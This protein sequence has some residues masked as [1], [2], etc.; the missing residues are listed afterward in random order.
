MEMSYYDEDTRT[1]STSF[2]SSGVRSLANGGFIEEII[3][4]V[5]EIQPLQTFTYK[6]GSKKGEEGS[7]KI[8]VIENTEQKASGAP[9]F[10][11]RV[12]IWADV[13]EK[14]SS[15]TSGTIYKLSHFKQVLPDNKRGK[16]FYG[17][18]IH[19]LPKSKVEPYF[20]DSSI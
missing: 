12:V 4:H 9:W 20:G 6:Q 1:D 8:V 11:Y 3:G 17:L 2:Y 7:V 18:D 10:K 15:I 16:G 19:L 13:A 5:S 14:F